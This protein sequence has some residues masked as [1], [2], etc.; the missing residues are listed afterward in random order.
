MRLHEAYCLFKGKLWT[1]SCAATAG[2]RSYLNLVDLPQMSGGIQPDIFLHQNSKY[3]E[4]K[5]YKSYVFVFKKIFQL[6]FLAVPSSSSSFHYLLLETDITQDLPSW[7]FPPIQYDYEG[8]CDWRIIYCTLI[9]CAM[10]LFAACGGVWVPKWVNMYLSCL[11]IHVAKG[12]IHCSLSF[13]CFYS[14]PG[15]G[16]VQSDGRE[17]HGQLWWHHL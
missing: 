14:V 16:Q 5:S 2:G 10:M 12:W 13:N 4:D 6:S 17:H 11:F 7:Y 8:H 9:L 15:G 3:H 1:L